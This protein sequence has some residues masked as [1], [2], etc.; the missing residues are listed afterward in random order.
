MKGAGTLVFLFLCLDL[1]FYGFCKLIGTSGDTKPKKR[2]FEEKPQEQQ[3][4]SQEDPVVSR[5]HSSFVNPKYCFFHFGISFII[6][7]R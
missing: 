4:T 1:F 3:K 5:S 6:F 2:L 7:G